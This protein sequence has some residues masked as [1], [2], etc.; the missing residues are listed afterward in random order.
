VRVTIRVQPRASRSEIVGRHGDAIRVRLTS[1]PVD[2]AAN[3]AL[4]ELLAQAFGVARGSIKIVS[5]A[6]SRTKVV[7]I[8]GASEAD[9]ARILAA[10][11]TTTKHQG[12]NG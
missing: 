6:T 12:R 1:P 10:A 2:G 3:A 8:D 7:D 9:V 5:G 4:I 11:P